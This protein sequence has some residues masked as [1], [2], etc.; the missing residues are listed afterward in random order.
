[1]SEPRIKRTPNVRLKATERTYRKKALKLLQSDFKNRCSYCLTDLRNLRESQAQI[2][3]FDAHLK[4]ILRHAYD[5][6]MLSCAGC[7]L[8]KHYRRIRDANDPQ[9]RMLNCTKE[10]EFP[11]HIVERRDSTWKGLTPA[12]E[13]HI[14]CMDLNDPSQV[15]MRRNRTHLFSEMSKLHTNAVRCSGIG[16]GTLAE[17]EGSL[18]TL[19]RELESALPFPTPLGLRSPHE[20]RFA[21]DVETLFHK[22]Q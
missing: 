1:M 21:T 4:E 3:H 14:K 2:D 12:G 9:K 6:L 20:I 8:A 10:N 18:E 16:P 13:Y 17:I 5:N 15:R 7:N 22:E 11:A 19:R